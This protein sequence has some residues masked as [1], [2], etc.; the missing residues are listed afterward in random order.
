M[1]ASIDPG[2]GRG[3]GQKGAG[4]HFTDGQTKAWRRQ[5][6]CLKSKSKLVTSL[7]AT[8]S[9]PSESVSHLKSVWMGKI[10]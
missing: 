9:F 1:S 6:S 8:L 10:G 3:K 5:L 4:T 2:E 7:E